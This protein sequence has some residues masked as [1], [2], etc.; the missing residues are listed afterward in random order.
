TGLRW[1]IVYSYGFYDAS[2][3]VSTAVQ[4]GT[5][6]LVETWINDSVSL[7]GTTATTF[8]DWNHIAVSRDSATGITTSYLN[9]VDVG[10]VANVTIADS[11][12]T[13][14]I[15]G[16]SSDIDYQFLGL[17]DE[18]RV[19]GANSDGGSRSADWIRA[20]YLSASGA[21]SNFLASESWVDTADT[22]APVLMSSETVDTNSDGYINAV[23]LTY[24]EAIVDSSFDI[25]DWDVAGVNGEVF[26][27]GGVANDAE[28]F[29]LF[30]DQVLGTGATPNVTYAQNA[31]V[32]AVGNLA[33][34]ATVTSVD[35]AA[36]VLM[37]VTGF[38]AGASN[39]F[40]DS[41]DV[42]EFVFSEAIAA[43]PTEADSE[44]NFVFVG[45]D[46]DNFPTEVGGDTIIDL[47][48]TNIAN[49][50]VRFTFSAG[51]TASANPVIA[52]TTDVDVNAGSVV[53][54]SIE[55]LAGNDLLDT[56]TGAALAVLWRVGPVRDNDLTA[57]A[58]NENAL[59]G[60]T[61]GITAFADD[62][63]SGDNVTY[64]LTDTAAGRFEI[65]ASTGVVTVDGTGPGLDFEAASSHDITVRATSDD[66]ST[67]DQLYTISVND[68]NEAP[69]FVYANEITEIAQNQ[70]TS[71][72]I[73][74]ADIVV[75]D[76]A[77]GSYIF[78]MTG[79][80]AALFEIDS[81]VLY[82]KAGTALSNA[83]NPVLDVRVWID[84][85]TLPVSMSSP[86][87]INVTPD[88]N[89]PSVSFANFVSTLPENT[90]TTARVKMAD[91]VI[92]DDGF[93]TNVLSLAGADAA[94]FEIDGTE[95]FLK[96]G[97]SL[98]FET[99]PQFDVSIEVNDPTLPPAP[100]DA[101]EPWWD[102]DWL[103]RRQITFDNSAAG[104]DLNSFP[105]LVR[106]TADD[107]DFGK[108]KAGGADIRFVD[109]GGTVL[110]YEIDSWDDG[111]ETAAVWVR[112]PV[113]DGG[114]TSDYF[115]M[116][117]NNAVAVDAQTPTAV[118][119][120]GLGVYHLDEDPGPGLP[121]DIEDS[122]ATP[123]PRNGQAINMESADLVAGLIGDATHFGGGGSGDYIDFPSTD[124]G[125]NFT[126]SAWI[127]PDATGTG[128]QTI[129]A[130]SASGSDTDGFRFFVNTVGTED[131][132]IRF[133]TGTGA[134]GN[135]ANTAAGVINFDEWN[136]VAVVVD[137]TSGV[138]T[139]YHNG[140]DVTTDT[141][142]RTDFDSS[143]DWELGRMEG[144]SNYFR[145]L[146]DELRISD[147]GR[148]ADWINASY[149]SQGANTTSA[150][151]GGE[152]AV[153]AIT[154]VNDAP[155]VDLDAGTGGVDYA[156]TFTEGDAATAIVDATVSLT[157][158]D[159]TT[160]V[161]VSFDSA[162]I[163]DGVDEQ[164]TIGDL[165]FDLNAGDFTNATVDIGG[166]TYTVNWVNA[167]GVATVTLNS[168]EMSVPQAQSVML[169]AAYQNTNT[170]K[171]TVGDRTIDVRVNDGD[172]DSAVATT[173]IT[174]APVN[175]APVV[176]AGAVT[177]YTENAVAVVIDSTV[178]ISDADD[179]EI[180]G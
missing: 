65:D 176:T 167:T 21:F 177:G 91:I 114:S 120:D 7:R 67:S 71:T 5:D 24:S 95:L 96:A 135:S 47:I 76:D 100:T 170:D 105:V 28:L 20:E 50:T 151:F 26:F 23:R 152:S 77:L 122:Y 146:V 119:P 56:A 108:I 41:G 147:T 109:P 134:A 57:N 128:I 82:L 143:S 102:S 15:G 144:G 48:T 165:T 27:T 113:V 168:G 35:T 51:D 180:A 162:G 79:A 9:G 125:N 36:P 158:Q 38:D 139:I 171:P 70:D 72:R 73:A 8:N 163:V 59:D 68:V 17:I 58:V 160:F 175:D 49:D 107:I 12:Q 150:R 18:V 179:T 64:S 75:S 117:Y 14:H 129:V 124:F 123:L 103:N 141:T 173:T 1:P 29:I 69:S 136:H 111:T 66:G 63:N 132:T 54:D 3:G 31:L 148:S 13:S 53:V 30:D 145:G 34:N 174:V 86:L 6:G 166:D 52:G 149:L 112:V 78:F 130:N 164:L 19:S 116:Y 85:A 32:D 74:V 94:L 89:P 92:T 61:V 142:I 4:A 22:A 84:D 169:S 43:A 81:E 97:T 40:A 44:T 110:D 88:N 156:F 115:H 121:G 138:A 157:D 104:A 178:T 11:G 60:T 90:D 161:N 127:K 159:D 137:R 16:H 25:N 131:G 106:L 93:G 126:I 118:W 155:V 140:V 55:D 33:A 83:L 45:V 154:D 46:G 133:E 80:D 99:N 153:V 39:V 172:I 101:G 2:I 87:S 98:D 42:L 62:P 37:A 10:T